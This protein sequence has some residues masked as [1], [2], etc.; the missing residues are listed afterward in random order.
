MAILNTGGGA[1]G[2]NRAKKFAGTKTRGSATARRKPLS[3]T[4]GEE[5]KKRP[6]AGT[7]YLKGKGT[8]TSGAKKVTTSKT[9]SGKTVKKVTKVVGTGSNKRVVKVTKTKAAGSSSYQAVKGKRQ[10]ADVKGR[11]ASGGYK[12]G[13]Y[14]KKDAKKGAGGGGPVKRQVLS[15]KV[16][17]VR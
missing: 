14:V 10:V 5:N 16:R 7:S 15:S 8:V 9:A 11:T 17:K 13:A 1:Y 6:L 3:E 12:T 4:I 2:R